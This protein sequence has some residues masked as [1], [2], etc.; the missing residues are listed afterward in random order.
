MPKDDELYIEASLD[1]KKSL[2]NIKTDIK[3]INEKLKDTKTGQTKITAGLNITDTRK[4]IQQQLNQVGS[5]LNLKVSAEIK[6]LKNINDEIN[7]ASSGR[8]KKSIPFEVDTSKISTE[9]KRIT[10][11]YENLQLK[12]QSSKFKIPD[13]LQTG[14]NDIKKNINDINGLPIGE[15]A[16]AINAVDAQIKTLNSDLTVS[17]KQ[18][19]I[20]A[21]SLNFETDKQ[22]LSNRITQWL[23][24]NTK[25]GKRLRTEMERLRDEINKA[26]NPS[27]LNSLRKQTQQMEQYARATNQAG[28]SM[29]DNLKNNVEKFSSW[30]SIGNVVS[31]ATSSIKNAIND[32]KDVDTILT[33]ISKTSDKTDSELKQLGQDSFD[34]ASKYG[35]KATDYLSGVKESARAGYA[36]PESMAELSTMAQSAGDMTA[37][38]AN[39][40][41]IAT[42][43]AYKLNGETEKLNAILDSQNMVT[44]RNALSMSDLAEATKIAGVQFAQSNINAKDMTGVLGTMMAVTQQGGDVAGRAAKGILMNLQQVEGAAEDIGDGGEAIT[45]ESLTKYEKACEALGVSLKEVK[46]GT[47]QLRDPMQV[48]KELS[49]SVSKESEGSIKVANLISAVGGKYRGNQLLALL[50]NWQ[51]YEK[52]IQDYDN[53]AGSAF[54][55][56]QKS[57]T[58][59]EGTLQRLINTWDSFIS[60]FVDG[61]KAKGVLTFF[62]KAIEA[63]DFLTDHLGTLG[64]VLTGVMAYRG[65]KNEGRGKLTPLLNM[66]SLNY[67]NELMIA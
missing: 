63:V 56:S 25:A 21:N 65:L 34:V 35:V 61:D 1:I 26:D 31:Q 6:G 14:L 67:N 2:S 41:L 33:E 37:E 7:K 64:T 62:T 5:K 42:D 46:D 66:L 23:N 3:T 9:I 24:E 36:N 8:G 49:E 12:F 45:T 20:L 40:Y 13:E 43:K 30:L 19:Q 58:N 52:I 50:K 11:A 55:E 22:K 4:L 27:A 60:G 38:L 47:Q 15:K 17:Q 16:G 18:S 53:G 32:L 10:A 54:E 59:W 51:T 57:A 44:N 39:Q 29:I 48:L 28:K